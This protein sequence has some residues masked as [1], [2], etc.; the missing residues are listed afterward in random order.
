M[1]FQR[2]VKVK[3]IHGNAALKLFFLWGFA[4]NGLSTQKWPVLHAVLRTLRQHRYRFVWRY[5]RLLALHR[6]FPTP[7]AYP[8]KI[9][10]R[11][12]PADSVSF[13]DCPKQS[14]RILLKCF[15]SVTSRRFEL[16][17]FTIRH[18]IFIAQMATRI[19]LAGLSS[20]I[21]CEFD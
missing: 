10:R 16:Y 11:P 19:H 18:V 15:H 5:A 2:R 3:F 21:V 1:A 7:A 14:F 4:P 6:F 20:I 17:T 9:L 8:K 13:S 12:R